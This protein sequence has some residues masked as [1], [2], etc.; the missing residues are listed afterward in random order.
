MKTPQT[1][2][3]TGKCAYFGFSCLPSK[4]SDNGRGRQK[5][6]SFNESC[7]NT[8]CFCCCFLWPFF[9]ILFNQC[10]ISLSHCRCTNWISC[11][12]VLPFRHV[13]LRFDTKHM[14]FYDLYS[15]KTFH[16]QGLNSVHSTC[17]SNILT[18][19]TTVKS[20]PSTSQIQINLFLV[21][22]INV[23]ITDKLI[24]ARNDLI[25]FLTAIYHRLGLQQH[26]IEW[27]SNH[28]DKHIKFSGTKYIQSVLK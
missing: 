11:I 13:S 10:S 3:P 25:H 24:V 26:K 21:Y 4:R 15:S 8:V 23:Y 28:Y 7:S 19:P 20:P 17:E 2:H 6:S 12:P 9:R 1:K 22:Q 18:A 16:R 14:F 5:I 27:T